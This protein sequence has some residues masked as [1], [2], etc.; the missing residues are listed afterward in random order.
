MVKF[1]SSRYLK[2]TCIKDDNTDYRE[3]LVEKML[4]YLNFSYSNTNIKY[5]AEMAFYTNHEIVK[6]T[7]CIY[8]V[9]CKIDN[10]ISFDLTSV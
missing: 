3:T 10:F 8:F 1:N 4:I 5:S 7:K 2:V 6:I 9:Y